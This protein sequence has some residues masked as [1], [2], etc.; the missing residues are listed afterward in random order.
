MISDNKIGL[1]GYSIGTYTGN[2]GVGALVHESA[3]PFSSFSV[4]VP[5][6]GHWND[7]YSSTEGSTVKFE[8]PSHLGVIYPELR[9]RTVWMLV[10]VTLHGYHITR[11]AGR[12]H[13]HGADWN[14]ISPFIIFYGSRSLT[15]SS[16]KQSF[17][18]V[19]SWCLKWPAILHG[20]SEA[21]HGAS[22]RIVTDVRPREKRHYREILIIYAS[23]GMWYHTQSPTN[24]DERLAGYKD[25][26]I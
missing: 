20:T 10:I 11:C 24:T 3:C 4:I 14:L 19:L 21:I 13:N 5:C 9:Q 12:N 16:H 1:E 8:T 18:L 17:L 6:Q 7:A 25:R 15:S 23:A 26:D 2:C 22:G